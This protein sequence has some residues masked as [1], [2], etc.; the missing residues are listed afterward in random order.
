MEGL[1][2]ETTL[3]NITVPPIQT[4]K[5]VDETFAVL[6]TRNSMII[7]FATMTIIGLLSIS[8]NSFMLYVI[9]RSRQLLEHKTNILVCN[10]IATDLLA[11]LSQIYAVAVQLKVNVFSGDPCH[12]LGLAAATQIIL[13][14]SL[15]AEKMILIAITVDR[16]MAIVHPLEY[17][18][19]FTERNAKQVIVVSWVLG[20]LGGVVLA[21]YL[22]GFDF[23]SCQPPYSLISLA[24]LDNGAY[25]LVVCVMIATYTRI[26]KVAMHQRSKIADALSQS[27]GSTS[28]RT[29]SELKAFRVF[30]MVLGTYTVLWFPYQVGRFLQVA[31]FIQSNTRAI[32]DAGIVLGTVNYSLDWLIY[33]VGS[34]SVRLAVVKLLLHHRRNNQE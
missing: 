12:Y 23:S 24:V 25:A 7:K 26:L 13:R 32:I 15:T 28:G 20:L 3:S 2:N 5:K 16:Y 19:R 8:G 10:L 33:G 29:N 17:E 22:I 30:A 27:T 21:L 6:Y 31:G 4:P 9:S 11:S 14:V 1:S 34:R 18:D